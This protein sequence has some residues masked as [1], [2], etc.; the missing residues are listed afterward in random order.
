MYMAA[1]WYL[2][3]D[4]CSEHPDD[5]KRVLEVLSKQ[6]PF[7]KTYS[8]DGPIDRLVSKQVI[9]QHMWDGAAE[10]A[11]QVLP[12]VRFAVPRE[13]ARL[14]QDSLVIPANA[15]NHNDAHRFIN[16]MMRPEVIA[17][18][19]NTLRYGNEI[20]GSDRYMDETLL[21]QPWINLPRDQRARLRPY[22]VCSAAALKMR[23]KVW[24]KLKG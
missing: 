23:N 8:N 1:S 22:K 15:K 7:V 20:T 9:V 17:K 3:Q 10:R 11:S 2:G 14:L 24:V 19:S 6:K 21:R 4:E 5:A 16:W 18:V 12:S 13:G